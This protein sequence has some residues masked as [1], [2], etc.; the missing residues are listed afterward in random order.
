MLYIGQT[1]SEGTL[2]TADLL[3]NLGAAL[4]REAQ[5]A[6]VK[7]DSELNTA[8]LAQERAGALERDPTF[9]TDE[10]H[11]LVDDLKDYL[12]GLAPPYA[13]VGTPEGD[14]ACIAVLPDW[15]CIEGEMVDGCMVQVGDPGELDNV[16]SHTALFVN[17]HG[18]AT[19]YQ[20]D[21]NQGGRWIEEWSVV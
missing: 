14:G 4:E 18:N 15:D 12:T 7:D 20:R 6:A 3:Q 19:L 8:R 9:E 21:D 2:R 5:A 13:Y 10:D 16:E 11:E 17:D 1:I